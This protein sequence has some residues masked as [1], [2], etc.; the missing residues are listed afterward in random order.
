MDEDLS[1]LSLK[2]TPPDLTVAY[3]SEPDQVADIRYGRHGDALP[4]LVL[5]HG[6]FWKPEYDRAHLDAMSAALAAAGWTVLTLEYRR[7]SGKP[8]VTLQDVANALQTLPN[9][10]EH[11]NGKIVLIGHS[12]G[13]QLV[14]WAAAKCT[15]PALQGVVALAPVADLRFA[16]KLRLGG[17]AVR[18]FLGADPQER[19]DVDPM[20][21]PAPAV[22][23]T[24]VQG[25][26]DEEV[27]AS[28]ATAYHAIFP[29]TRLLN[30][31]DTGHY[32]LIDPRSSAWQTVLDAIRKLPPS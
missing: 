17:G 27:P 30:L 1:I 12:A 2:A 19:P 4:L 24:I 29:N 3:G 9:K 13:G 14:L 16:D 28:V 23:V 8:D 31:P 21:L 25:N 6:G 10:V 7:I 32:A 5:I 26:D 11:H 15:W 18:S 22:A 20:Q